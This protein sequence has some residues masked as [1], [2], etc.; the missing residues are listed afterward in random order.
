MTTSTQ[1]RVTSGGT[2]TTITVLMSRLHGRPPKHSKAVT[3]PLI[4][5]GEAYVSR[6][7]SLAYSAYL[8]IH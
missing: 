6:A 3:F 4:Y 8:N 5:L 2:V 7:D 1:Q